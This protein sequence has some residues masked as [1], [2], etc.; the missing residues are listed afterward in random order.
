VAPHYLRFKG[1]QAAAESLD[2]NIVHE[3]SPD[4]MTPS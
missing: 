1:I 2:L 4:G 3:I